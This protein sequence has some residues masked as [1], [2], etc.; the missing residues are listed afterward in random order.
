MGARTIGS[1]RRKTYDTALVRRTK[2]AKFKGKS[3]AHSTCGR[4]FCRNCLSSSRCQYGIFQISKLSCK[5]I[6]G[7][8]LV[9]NVSSTSPE[10]WEW[11]NVR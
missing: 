5:R 4:W 1:S 8:A 9:T 6:A 10:S 2:T 3:Y 7:F 11:C